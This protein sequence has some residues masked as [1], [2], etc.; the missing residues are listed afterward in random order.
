ME[1]GVYT[2]ISA[3]QEDIAKIGIGKDKTN[4]QQG[5]KFRG[6]DDVYDVLSPILAKH[7]LCILPNVLNRHVVERITPKGTALFYVTVECAFDLVSA[8]DGSKHTIKTF[9]EAMDS[10]DKA[11]NKAMSAAYKYAAFQTFCIPVDA[12]DADKETHTVKANSAKTGKVPPALQREQPNDVP[13]PP[14]PPAEPEVKMSQ[15]S[16]WAIIA[17]LAGKLSWTKEEIPKACTV[18][19]GREITKAPELT[20][21]EAQRCIAEFTKLV[22]AKG[23]T[24]G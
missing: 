23:A 5:Y 22:E 3:V 9:G 12:E 10:G 18:T 11:T 21:D 19:I 14:L 7:K 2:E 20:F 16:Q 13:E 15:R 17:Q 1:L 8:L 4:Q 6:I 24:N